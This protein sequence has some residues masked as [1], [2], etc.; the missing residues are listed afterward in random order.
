VLALETLQKVEKDGI[1]NSFVNYDKDKYKEMILYAAETV[2]DYFGFDRNVYGNPENNRKKMK[3]YQE[4]HEERTKD[5][6]VER[7]MEKQ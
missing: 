2:L 7:M 5:I 4:L 6:Q 3:W 1:E